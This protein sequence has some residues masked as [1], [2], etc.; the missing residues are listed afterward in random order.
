[1]SRLLRE[2]IGRTDAVQRFAFIRS[3]TKVLNCCRVY[4]IPPL[5]YSG[6]LHPSASCLRRHPQAQYLLRL[7]MYGQRLPA[8]CFSQSGVHPRSLIVMSIFRRLSVHYEE[9]RAVKEKG[10]G[11][12]KGKTPHMEVSPPNLHGWR[13]QERV[14]QS[15]SILFHQL[16]RTSI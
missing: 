1:M 2:N 5:P 11:K 6:S 16:Q 8:K 12:G 15:N 3:T 9:K 13:L 10:K 4:N 14:K 7:S